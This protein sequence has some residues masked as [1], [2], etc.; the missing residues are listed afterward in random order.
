M[1]Q[2]RSRHQRPSTGRFHSSV[3]PPAVEINYHVTGRVGEGEDSTRLDCRCEVPAAAL[4][5]TPMVSIPAPPVM[6]PIAVFNPLSA[7]RS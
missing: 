5:A 4:A 3:L 6:V 1:K 7:V 2:S